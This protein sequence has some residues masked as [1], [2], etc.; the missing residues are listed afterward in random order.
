MYLQIWLPSQYISHTQHTQL[1]CHSHG[2]M[3]Q[4][5]KL[6]WHIRAVLT[7]FTKGMVTESATSSWLTQLALDGAPQCHVIPHKIAS[8]RCHLLAVQAFDQARCMSCLAS[9]ASEA[10]LVLCAVLR[11][12]LRFEL[13][14]LRCRA[15]TE[16]I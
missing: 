13:S 5:L 7:A 9:E 1:L 15:C 12:T 6:E 3:L 8:C 11:C 2:N 14:M 16:T 4:V 10:L